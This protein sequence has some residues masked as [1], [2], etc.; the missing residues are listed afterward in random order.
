ML[1]M[2]TAN[3]MRACFMGETYQA[4]A[5]W[6]STPTN[7]IELVGPCEIGSALQPPVIR[8]RAVR[9]DQRCGWINGRRLRCRLD[10][11]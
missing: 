11:R 9:L 10:G 2:A 5:A 8:S 4:L 3:A 1:A 7:P 6:T